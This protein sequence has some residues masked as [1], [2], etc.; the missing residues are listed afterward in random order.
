MTCSA[1]QFLVCKQIKWLSVVY[2]IYYNT[3]I[4]NKHVGTVF[5][6]ILG[7]AAVVIT[8][9]HVHYNNSLQQTY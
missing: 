9:Q 5:Y 7:S 8:S 2:V 4:Y 1:S 3:A 6:G